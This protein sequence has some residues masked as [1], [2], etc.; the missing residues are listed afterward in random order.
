MK[1]LEIS[2]VAKRTNT[3]A[4]TLRY[5]EEKGLITPSG[6]RGQRRVYDDD[7]L[8]RLAL[9]AL[10]RVSGFS[11][12]EI[13]LMFGPDGKPDIKRQAL[14]AKADQLE[15]KIAKLNVMVKGL[16]HAA[17]CSAPSH[18]ECP[19]FRRLMK[20]AAAATKR[21][22]NNKKRPGGF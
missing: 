22:N 9:I 17:M 4:S 12:D 18:M 10:G 19:K 16:R 8:D 6:R 1:E 11:L 2:T 21:A 13:A 5:Y 14:T 7:V 20:A 3:P 15:E